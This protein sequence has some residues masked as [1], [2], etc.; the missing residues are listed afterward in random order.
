MQDDL[1]KAYWQ[2]FNDYHAG[3]SAVVCPFEYGSMLRHQY[4]KGYTDGRNS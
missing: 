1:S 4:I 2:G 3:K